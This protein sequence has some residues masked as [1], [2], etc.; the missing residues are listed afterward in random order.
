MKR[1]VL[2]REIGALLLAATL[3]IPGLAAAEPL[4]PDRFL[5]EAELSPG[6]FWDFLIGI[7]LED[8]APPPGNQGSG[9][10]EG[11]NGGGAMDPNGGGATGDP[12]PKPNP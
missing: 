1:N 10:G 4:G 5:A 6:T 7:F 8:H 2:R 9:G 12:K 3:G 11:S